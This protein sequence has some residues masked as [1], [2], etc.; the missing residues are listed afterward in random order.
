[1]FLPFIIELINGFL[2]RRTVLFTLALD[3][4]EIVENKILRCFSF[5]LAA[6]LSVPFVKQL[7]HLRKVSVCVGFVCSSRM[8]IALA[9]GC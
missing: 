2:G 7:T 5:L 9:R 8:V 3:R 1:M 6:L 4:G